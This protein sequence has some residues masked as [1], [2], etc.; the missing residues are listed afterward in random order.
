M[1]EARNRSALGFIL[2]IFLQISP[3][4]ASQVLFSKSFTV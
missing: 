2:L 4:A 3:L 1:Q